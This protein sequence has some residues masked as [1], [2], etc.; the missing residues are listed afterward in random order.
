MSEEKNLLGY[1]TDDV[2]ST[3]CVFGKASVLKIISSDPPSSYLVLPSQLLLSSSLFLI[4][5][6]LVLTFPFLTISSYHL[7]IPLSFL[8][9][10]WQLT[11]IE[12]VCNEHVTFVLTNS[13]S[14]TNFINTCCLPTKS[15]FLHNY[16]ERYVAKVH[17][18]RMSR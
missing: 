9:V 17:A 15:F 8:Q 5:P 7:L 14:G 12:H 4:H 6:S 18:N 1:L 3:T 11:N 10:V 16:L 2:S 13:A